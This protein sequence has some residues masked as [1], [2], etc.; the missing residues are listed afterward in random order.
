MME[1]HGNDLER[2]KRLFLKP[3]LEMSRQSTRFAPYIEALRT[4]ST[5]TGSP[6][7][8]L[9]LSFAIL[10]EITAVAPVASFFFGARALGVGDRIVEEVA[11]PPSNSGTVYGNWA[12]EK[13]REWVDEG[14]KWAQRVGT[15]YGVFG[16][17][18]QS[19]EERTKAGQEDVVIVDGGLSSRLAGDAAN[20]ILAYGLTKVHFHVISEYTALIR[21]PGFTASSNRAIALFYP[22]ILSSCCRTC[23]S[24]SASSIPSP[25]V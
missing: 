23:P 21:L 4:I 11:R 17:E 6:L 13:G 3:T 20:A 9:I 8:S 16:F 10:H 14:G 7:P 24:N 18:K 15:R 12:R 5:R 25:L 2:H 19:K 1:I 22:S